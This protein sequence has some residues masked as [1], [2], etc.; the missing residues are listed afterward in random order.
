MNYP[1]LPPRTVEVVI[2]EEHKS[3]LAQQAATQF[4]TERELLEELIDDSFEIAPVL[5]VLEDLC[6]ED[7]IFLEELES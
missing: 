1:P 5:K 3:K 7:E 6:C 2:S 4:R